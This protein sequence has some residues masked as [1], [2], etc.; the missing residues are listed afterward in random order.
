MSKICKL[1]DDE[2]ASQNY[3]KMYLTRLKKYTQPE[4][5]FATS[6]MD[7]NEEILTDY[8]TVRE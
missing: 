4:I 5:E 7:N 8:E 3:K 1:E 6:T 2:K